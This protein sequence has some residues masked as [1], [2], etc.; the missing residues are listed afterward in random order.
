MS[1]EAV[2]I[3]LVWESI[4]GIAG[5]VDQAIDARKDAA[6]RQAE[7]EREQIRAWQDFQ[8]QQGTQQ[9]HLRRS[10]EALRQAHQQL[11]S[12]GLSA[13][14][15]RNL[16]GPTSE[17][18]VGDAAAKD[19]HSHTGDLLHRIATELDELP[20]ELYRDERLPFKRLRGH[21]RRLQQASAPTRDEIYSLR[22]TLKRTLA[23][24][25][26][27]IAREAEQH[28]ILFDKAKRLL[29]EILQTRALCRDQKHDADLEKMQRQLTTQM[30]DK[31][32]SLAAMDIFFTRFQTLRDAVH[33]DIN[34][35]EMGEFL[36]QRVTHHLT[37]MGYAR[38]DS[39]T[40]DQPGRRHD[41][42]FALPQGDRLRVAL[43]PDLRMAFQLTHET[44]TVLEKALTGEA[45][46][47]F[48]QQEARWCRDMKELIR[49]LVKDGVPYEVQF[50]REMPQE[51]IPIVV[52]ETADELLDEEQ[53]VRRRHKEK[54]QRYFT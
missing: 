37:T 22:E 48:R 43:Q 54:R 7:M 41:A 5:A 13:A 18:F 8:L 38:L 3:P 27:R 11:L 24:S 33:H 46:E 45:L 34:Q 2:L 52:V 53:D 49:R 12:V 35:V 29:T 17:G 47:F 6:R 51:S 23:D 28:E 10:H 21:L 4:T 16:G 1:G 19:H 15:S 25:I 50:E 39:N 40:T 9:Q 26:E 36:L 31:R 30:R 32:V 14:A 42:E 20:A 44:E